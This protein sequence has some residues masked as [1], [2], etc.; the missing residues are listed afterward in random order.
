MC[1]ILYPFKRQK[2]LIQEFRAHAQSGIH[3]LEYVIPILPVAAVFLVYLNRDAAAFHRILNCVAQ[4]IETDLTD[5]ERIT[6][7]HLILYP[8]Q[9]DVHVKVIRIGLWAYQ[10]RNLRHQIRKVKRLLPQGY[11]SALNLRHIQ[12]IINQA[13]Q[14]LA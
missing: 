3:A 4:N 7:H 12:N 8:Q 9:T 13:Q 10:L 2:K 14:M 1:G 6:D 11:L 5:S